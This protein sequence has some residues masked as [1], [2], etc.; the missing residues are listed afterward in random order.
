M[1][2]F[3][4]LTGFWRA[5][6]TFT[7]SASDPFY[8]IRT[9][10]GFSG[11]LGHAVTDQDMV[12]IIQYHLLEPAPGNSWSGTDMFDLDDVTRALQQRRDQFLAETGVVVSEVL[13]GLGAPP[14]SRIDLSTCGGRTST[15]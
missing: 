11:L 13:L 9:A 7:T 15:T 4:V 2:V 6:A 8:D 12:K 3:G 1:R 14:D 10:G 5:Q